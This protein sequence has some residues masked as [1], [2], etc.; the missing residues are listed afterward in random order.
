MPSR[1]PETSVVT[2][3]ADETQDLGR[4]LG[5]RLEAGDLCLLHGDLG[6]GKTTFTQGIAWGAG[7]TGYAHSPTFV[8]VHE[9]QGRITLYHLDLYR[10][11]DALEVHD[12]GTDEMLMNGACVVEWAD[13]APGV[14]PTEHLAVALG[15]GP[16]EDDRVVIFTP[17]GERYERVVSG[18]GL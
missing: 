15:Q 18:M 5:A 4:R 6:A 3:S 17:H 13:K 8:L 9:Y 1:M 10:L 16:A 2:H 11:D 12:L 14:F 7:V